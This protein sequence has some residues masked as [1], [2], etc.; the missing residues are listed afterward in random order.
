MGRTHLTPIQQPDDQSCGP[1]A[2]KLA[3][4]MFGKRK[5]L[6]TLAKLCKTNRNGT[7]T[8]NMIK[9]LNKLGFAVELVEYATLKHVQSA[10]KY[11]PGALRAALVTYLYDLDEKER[12]HPDSGHWAPVYSYSS[13]KNRIVL[14]DSINAKKKSYLWSDFRERWIDFD[15]KRRTVD[16]GRTFKLV[17]KWQPQLLMIVARSVQHLPKFRI[18][19]AKVF[20]PAKKPARVLQTNGYSQA[21]RRVRRS[22]EAVRRSA[23]STIASIKSA[24]VIPAAL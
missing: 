2:M 13:S 22:S 12:P 4:Q 17:R 14:L 16:N 3:L 10:L 11:K 5:S 15:L 7:S 20:E 23:E 9:A 19:T 1:A 8:K 21:A 24:N 6:K 18:S